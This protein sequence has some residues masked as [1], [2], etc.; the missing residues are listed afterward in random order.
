MTEAG[1]GAFWR[2][3]SDVI[4]HVGQSTR[5]LGQPT[6]TVGVQAGIS[7][8]EIAPE[9]SL[10]P[11]YTGSYMAHVHRLGVSVALEPVLLHQFPTLP[12]IPRVSSHRMNSPVLIAHE[13]RLTSQSI[14]A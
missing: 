4:V 6:T 7:A 9:A 13:L 5:C 3:G 8:S 1:L 11:L 10:I 2:V 14:Q 12:T